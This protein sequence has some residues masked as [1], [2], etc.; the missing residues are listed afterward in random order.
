MR[1]KLVLIHKNQISNIFSTKSI[2]RYKI[3]FLYFT[4]TR[5]KIGAEEDKEKQSIYYIH[6][7]LKMR[8]SASPTYYL[9][10]ATILAL[11]LS[12]VTA[13]PDLVIEVFRNG[14]SGPVNNTYDFDNYWQDNLGEITSVGMRQ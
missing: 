1:K 4:S 14:A 10:V 13:Q 6:I 3:Y 8:V 2:Y 7:S 11:H 9:Y 12:I 5:R